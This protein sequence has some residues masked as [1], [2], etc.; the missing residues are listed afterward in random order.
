VNKLMGMMKADVRKK[1]ASGVREGKRKG[2]R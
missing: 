2:K 1:A